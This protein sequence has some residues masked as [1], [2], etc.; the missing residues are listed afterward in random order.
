[1]IQTSEYS[2]RKNFRLYGPPDLTEPSTQSFTETERNKNRVEYAEV[3]Q[4]NSLFPGS[5]LVTTMGSASLLCGVLQK[6]Q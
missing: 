4:C 3:T 6:I 5:E 2:F 1:M